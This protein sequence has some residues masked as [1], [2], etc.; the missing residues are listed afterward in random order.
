MENSNENETI[1]ELKQVGYKIIQGK[2]SFK[3]GIDAFLLAWY[4][5]SCEG[6]RNNSS[7]IDLCTGS[8][9]VPLLL[10][11]KSRAQHISALEIQPESASMASRSVEMNSL[12]EKIQV[13]QGDVK[14]VSGL[15]KKHSFNVVTC[16][17]PY[18]ISDHG[19]QNPEDAKAIAR[20][21]VLCN[22]E[23]VVAAAD[24]LLKEHGVFYMIHRPFRVAEIFACLNRHKME[25]KRIRFI[26][27]F[28]GEEPNLVLIEARKNANPRLLVERPLV[29]YETPGNYTA[30]VKGIYGTGES[31]I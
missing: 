21:E 6:I 10:S 3:F 28:A 14:Q 31:T 25:P 2:S 5:V 16:N 13:V 29:V 18:M 24:Y 17:P 1:D 8:G 19:K 9:I 22:L 20:F 23:D 11:G 26:H 27:P 4:A 12:Q 30:E 7:V 15:F